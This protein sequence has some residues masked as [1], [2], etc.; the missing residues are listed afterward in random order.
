MSS[1]TI[2]SLEELKFLIAS[3]P[4]NAETNLSRFD[5]YRTNNRKMLADQNPNPSANYF[6]DAIIIQIGQPKRIP[7]RFGKPIQVDFPE[8]NSI[9]KEVEIKY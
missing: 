1:K 2:K 5:N 3:E 4:L 6:P 9:P 8:P 7:I